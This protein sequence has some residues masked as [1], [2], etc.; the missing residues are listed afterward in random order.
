VGIIAYAGPE[1]KL[2]LNQKKPPFKTSRLDKRLNKCDPLFSFPGRTDR[3]SGTNLLSTLLSP[4]PSVLIAA[5]KIRV[6]AVRSEYAHQLG[7]GY[8]RRPF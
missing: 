3:V 7:H 4:F 6:G 2:S 1:T 8:L 5:K